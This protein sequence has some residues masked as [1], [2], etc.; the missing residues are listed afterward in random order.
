[1]ATTKVQSELIVDDVALAGNP[2][3]TTQS[4]GNNTTRIATTAFV[5]TAVDNLIASAPG[6]M[7]TL[8]EIAAAL[9][10][11]PS[12]TTTVNNAIATKAPLASPSLTGTVTITGDF[13]QLYFV[14]SAGT[15]LDAYVVNNANGLFFGKTNSPSASN[16]ILS[17][18]LS[19]KSATFAGNVTVP[20]LATTSYIDLNNSGNRGKIGWSGN[21]TYIA[22]TSSVGS[23]IFKNNVSS[24]AAPQTGGDTLLTLAD[25]GDATFAGTVTGTQ[26]KAATGSTTAAVLKLEDSGVATYDFSFPDTGTILLGVND[27][28]GTTSDKVLKLHNAGSGRLGLNAEGDIKTTGSLEVASS[29]PRIHLDRGDGSYS[30]NIYNGDGTG[31]F[32]LSTFNI[33][34]N[35]G[36][37][38]LTAYDGGQVLIGQ[39]SGDAFHADSMLRLQRAGDRVFMQFKTDAN[40][41]SG[42]LFG[43]VDDDVECGIEYEPG[44]RALVFSSGNNA[45]AFRI[46]EN[47]RIGVNTNLSASDLTAV[48]PANTFVARREGYHGGNKTHYGRTFKYSEGNSWVSAIRIEWDNPSWAG[49]NLRIKGQGY[50]NSGDAFDVV[51]GLQG[52]SAATSASYGVTSNGEGN[53]THFINIYQNA[54]GETTIQQRSSNNTSNVEDIVFMYEW[55][56]NNRSNQ[57]VQVLDL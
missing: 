23:I 42:I 45:E 12:F 50:Y 46:D 24:T 28:S 2:T 17:L 21:H 7:D 31:N 57:A 16:D 52:H 25:G 5:T 39:D 3:T 8:N 15:D 37:A 48:I 43:D 55:V 27:Q 6:T 40:Q 33:A 53:Y 34:N 29:Q 51:I 1:M 56:T 30:W 11:D 35:G 20:Y 41:N 19:D 49:V 4:A 26:L 18:N 14:D 44:N 38:V 9:G 22:T 36:T 47:G 54:T 32:P 13:P 10:D